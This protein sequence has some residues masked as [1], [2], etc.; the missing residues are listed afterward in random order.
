MAKDAC[1]NA[2]VECMEEV[3]KLKAAGLFMPAVEKRIK[4]IDE[5]ARSK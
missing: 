3:N 5:R 4:D 2:P 1:N